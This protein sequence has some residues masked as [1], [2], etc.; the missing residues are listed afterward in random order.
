MG[1]EIKNE[2]VE[3]L[4]IIRCLEEIHYLGDRDEQSAKHIEHALVALTEGYGILNALDYQK[5]FVDIS[6]VDWD[7][8]ICLWGII[9][10]YY[11]LY[12]K[13]VIYNAFKDFRYGGDLKDTYAYKYSKHH[14]Q[15]N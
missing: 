8:C 1:N 2:A 6:E 11:L 15:N 13:E 12:G 4:E 3:P 7:Q 10:E 14:Y 9:G 5:P